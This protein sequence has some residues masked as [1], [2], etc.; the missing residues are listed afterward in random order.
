MSVPVL[1]RVAAILHWIIAVGFGV[2]CLPAIRKLLK[3]ATD[4]QDRV[5]CRPPARAAAARTRLRRSAAE[6]CGCSEEVVTSAETA[7]QTCSWRRGPHRMCLA[8]TKI[9]REDD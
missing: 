2:F 5:A 7:M 3:G 8:A 9:P 6:E 1:L 4:D